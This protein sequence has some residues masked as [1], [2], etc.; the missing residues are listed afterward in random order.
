MV[1]APQFRKIKSA[2]PAIYSPACRAMAP[3]HIPL[4]ALSSP[5]RIDDLQSGKVL[6]TVGNHDAIIR[7]GHRGDDHVQRA[8]RPHRTWLRTIAGTAQAIF[9]WRVLAGMLA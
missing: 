1:V 9:S 5:Q 8:L 4:H 3:D 7:F 2:F 6:F